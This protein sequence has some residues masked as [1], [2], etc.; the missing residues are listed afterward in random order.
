MKYKS[1]VVIKLGGLD[2]LHVVEN[3]LDLPSQRKARLKVLAAP[4]CTPDFTAR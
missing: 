2:A 4:V 1:L 3:E